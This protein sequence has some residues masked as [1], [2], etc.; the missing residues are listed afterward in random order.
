MKVVMLG[1]FKIQHKIKIERKEEKKRNI[2][3]DQ[4]FQLNSIASFNSNKRNKMT[5]NMKQK[6]KKKKKKK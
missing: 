1:S 5:G 4:P 2:L 6:Q 3:L